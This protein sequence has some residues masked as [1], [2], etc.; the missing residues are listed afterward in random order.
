MT[1]KDLEPIE[2]GNLNDP[3]AALREVMGAGPT[4]ERAPA[5]EMFPPVQTE[6]PPVDD[7]VQRPE[8]AV[9][10]KEETEEDGSVKNLLLSKMSLPSDEE[11]ARLKQHHRV[12]QL[13]VVPFAMDGEWNK[14]K[15]FILKSI[16]RSKW[17][18]LSDQ[19]KKRAES[20]S[21]PDT[22]DPEDV[23]ASYVVAEACVHPKMEASHLD[24]YPAGLVPTL[25]AVVHRISWFFDP[26]RL[27]NL[28]I[29]L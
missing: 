13:T 9:E 14:I 1:I 10:A 25:Y 11:I 24:A 23:F 12:N 3:E 28:S 29:T 21:L 2:E 22:A 27:I 20:G 17:R 6:L 26:E 7:I 18:M 4:V 19:I 16:T 8:P 5:Q 15:P